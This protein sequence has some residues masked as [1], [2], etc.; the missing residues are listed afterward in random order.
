MTDAIGNVG[1]AEIGDEFIAGAYCHLK[2]PYIEVTRDHGRN[3]IEDDQRCIR[4]QK[5]H[6][7]KKQPDAT[8]KHGSSRGD[9]PVRS[10]ET[11]Q[12]QCESGDD[13]N[14]GYPDKWIPDNKL[15]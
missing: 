1:I 15:N 7:L 8:C 2:S 12:P 13:T 5:R 10:A 3:G 6:F 11:D 9:N 14:A 4:P